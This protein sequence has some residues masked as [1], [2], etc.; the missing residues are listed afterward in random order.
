MYAFQNPL[1]YIRAFVRRIQSK[2]Q[3]RK[4]HPKTVK[5]VKR[6]RTVFT[7]FGTGPSRPTSRSQL[8]LEKVT[9]NPNLEIKESKSFTGLLTSL[10]RSLIPA[11]QISIS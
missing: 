4:H 5:T 7:F 8:V 2:R 1:V 3:L 10:L 11:V 9:V 6:L